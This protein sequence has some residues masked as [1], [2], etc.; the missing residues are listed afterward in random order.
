MTKWKPRPI[1]V[2]EPGPLINTT[3]LIDLMLVLLVMLMLSI[4]L[5]THEMPLDVPPPR[6]TPQGP[7]PPVHRLD[8]DA[9]GSLSWDGRPIADAELPARLAG[10]VRDPAEPVLHFAAA[11]ETRYARVDETLAIVLRAG[12][13]RMGFVGNAQFHRT[14]DDRPG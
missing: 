9:A 8:I 2:P 11:G 10:M 13:T 6:E 12:V 3:P 14:L 4:P 7:P 5:A 1:V